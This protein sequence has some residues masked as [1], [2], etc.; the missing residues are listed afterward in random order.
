MRR[1]LRLAA[2]G[3]TYPNPMVGCVL[4]RDGE[5]VGEGWHPAAGQPHA[6]VFAL[7][8][9]GERARGATAYVSLEPCAHFGRTPPCADALIAAGVG[10]VV[11]AVVD[12][13]P[14]VAGKGLA[15]LRAAGIPAEAGVLEDE[16]RRLNEAF[17]H[18]HAT[19]GP[20]VIL[21]A[22]TTLDG[23]IATRTGDSKWITGPRARAWVH[24]LRARV[25]AVLCGV[26]TV[27]ADDPLLT[28]RFRGA[29]R[30]PL[31]IV[32]DPRLRTPPQ[33]NLARTARESPVLVVTTD[34][35]DPV[36]AKTLHDC[37]LEVLR[38]PAETNNQLPLGLLL[39]ELGRRG[40]QSV[41]VEGGGTTYAA[42]LEGR[43]AHRLHWF[44]A[45]K[46]VGGRDA[47]TAVEGLGVARMADAVAL[48][49]ITIR[50][51]GP[52]LRIDG[53]LDYP[54]EKSG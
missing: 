30:Q 19:G 1:A 45:P 20:L 21:K 6:E 26:G 27:L 50:R 38:L 54:T 18:Y 47:P 48:R 10:R 24:R 35:A 3:Y 5:V 36:R 37:G 53:E 9:A 52:D 42:I 33:S 16:A 14:R 22:A 49:E 13:D 12:P 23:K 17:F 15:R 51:L 8:Q 11:A 32:L 31:R 4:V 44:V 7:R 40:I 25:G 34:A 46:L 28:A 41:L 39:A 29:P 2:R 43:L